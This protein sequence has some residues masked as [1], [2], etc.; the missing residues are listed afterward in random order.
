MSSISPIYGQSS[1][2]AQVFGATNSGGASPPRP[3]EEKLDSVLQSSGLNAKDQAA[4]K[5][6]LE[7]AFQDA[8]SSGSFPPDASQLQTTLKD[9]F[10]KY[11]VNVDDFAGRL[12]PGGPGGGLSGGGFGGIVGGGDL[13]QNAGSLLDL[14]N[15][16]SSSAA[17]KSSTKTDSSTSKSEN[18]ASTQLLDYLKKLIEQYGERSGSRAGSDLSYRLLGFDTTV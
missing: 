9:V 2:F 7:S 5:N 10:A 17:E 1:Q 14:L 18:S 12:Q 6:D 15:S 16:S 13:Q 4:L 8:F 11:G 3:L